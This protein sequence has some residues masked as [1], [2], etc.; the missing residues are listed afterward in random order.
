MST[1]DR[2]DTSIVGQWWWTVDRWILLAVGLLI[3]TGTMLIMAASPSVAERIGLGPWHFAQRQVIFLIPA[4]ASLFVISLMTARGVRRIAVIGFIGSLALMVAALLFGPE[5]KGAHRWLSFAGVSVQPS[6][7]VKPF[8]A[9]TA[10]WMFAAQKDEA[11][12]PGN[13]IACL[14]YGAVASV[15]VLQ[16]DLGMTVVVTAVW[17][18]QFFIAGLSMYIVVAMIGL[19]VGGGLLAYMF[20]PH[21][22]SRV[23]RFLDPASGDNYQIERAMEAFTNGG[24]FGRGPGEGS[25]KH[26]LPDAHTDFIYAV[27]GE[28]FGLFVCL[29]ILALFGFITLRGL[30]RLLRE[31]DLFVL[32]AASGLLI[33]FGLQ[34]VINIGVNLRLL[35]TKGMTLPFISYGG[36]SLVALAIGMGMILA[37]T[38]TR[39]QGRYGQ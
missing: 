30:G 11:G 19:A 15:L 14:L 18:G 8:F 24:A 32:L 29:I 16:P 22:T 17:L 7:F 33:Q 4:V 34:A 1:L 12:V 38:R 23:D 36:S 6:E 31:S 2:T 39:P 9:V 10:A 27:A 20:F 3:A 26:V 37:L 28:E 21:V 35:P 13:L 5:I 25:V